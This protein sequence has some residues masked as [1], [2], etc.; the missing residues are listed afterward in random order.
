[1]D[2]IFS[3]SNWERSVISHTGTQALQSVSQ[4]I[5][6]LRLSNPEKHAPTAEQREASVLAQ[7]QELHDV[8]I[9]CAC[10]ST[11]QV[12]SFFRGKLCLGGGGQTALERAGPECWLALCDLMCYPRKPIAEYEGSFCVDHMIE[13]SLFTTKGRDRLTLPDNLANYAMLLG[14]F[15]EQGRMKCFGM[16]KRGWYG[17]KWSAMAKT[18]MR[19]RIDFAEDHHRKPTHAEFMEKSSSFID[20]WR[21]SRNLLPSS[22]AARANSRKRKAQSHIDTMFRVS[23]TG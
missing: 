20:S 9:D 5:A 2:D 14:F 23:H 15:N 17:E 13:R 10:I 8:F 4:F 18:A 22:H 6:E 1:M 3:G 12:N 11:A 16:E 19:F 21:P 7:Y